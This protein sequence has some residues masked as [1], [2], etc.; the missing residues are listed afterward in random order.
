MV[1]VLGSTLTV[2]QQDFALVRVHRAV[3]QDQL[4]GAFE[5]VDLLTSGGDVLC[6][7]ILLLADWEID[8]DRDRLA[9]R[10][11]DE[12]LGPTR[13]PICTSAIPAT[14]STS[15]VTLVQPRSSCCAL[16]SRLCRFDGCLCRELGLDFVI[17]L[18]LRNGL[19]L[20]KRSIA[21][22][23][24]RRS[25][26]LGLRLGK[27]AFGAVKSRLEGSWV[28]L[29]QDLSFAD[30]RSFFVVLADDVAGHLRPYLGV[31][32]TVQARDP[33]T[34]EWDVTLNRLRD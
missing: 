3:G 15:E 10:K 27:I 28:Y 19:L 29:E 11:S 18:G 21:L 30:S 34:L 1:P 2:R 9:K 23:V 20:S 4:R 31:D 17:E 16:H 22:Y 7:Q 32:V 33:F 5:K 14:P 24:E 25:A 6:S 13:L 26:Q 8:L 12:T